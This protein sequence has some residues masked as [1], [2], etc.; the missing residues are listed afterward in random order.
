[1]KKVYTLKKARENRPW[2]VMAI[3]VFDG[4][5]LGHRDILKT[6]RE[7]ARK[8]KTVASV[9]T[10][11]PHPDVV[12]GKR[13]S[14]QL[15]CSLEERLRLL[16]HEHVEK[17]LIMVLDKEFSLTPPE[18]F[19]N[20]ILVEVLGVSG[21]V[22]GENFRFGRDAAADAFVLRE[23]LKEHRVP[24]EIV[25]RKALDGEVISSSY[26]RQRLSS[27]HVEVANRYLG[28]AYSVTGAVV[29]GRGLGKRI[30]FPTVNI[31]PFWRV[32]LLE[33]VYA[34]RMWTGE[35]LVDGVAHW[36][37]RPTLNEDT[38]V[39]EVHVLRESLN[40]PPE[41]KVRVY[42]LHWL[43]E[44]QRFPSLEALKNQITQDVEKAEKYFAGVEKV[45]EP[46]M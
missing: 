20:N 17:C 44:V 38:P 8:M 34:V 32:I 2:G 37:R 45:F 40:I 25:P 10:F 36:G 26:I 5:H 6:T 3:G 19:V 39:L 11:H 23:L 7:L 31:K 33:G 9:M 24:V 41:R 12:L 22:V 27:G 30:G 18:R 29:Q 4:V 28:H 15:I 1:M 46:G 43:R 35:A 42:F 16:E 14:L 21:V 13:L